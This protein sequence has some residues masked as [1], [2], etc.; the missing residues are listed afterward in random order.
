MESFGAKAVRSC[1]ILT[2]PAPKL[3]KERV[4]MAFAVALAVDAIQIPITG[5]TD[6]IAA[7]IPGEVADF[8]VDCIAMAAISSLIGFHRALIPT[9][10]VELI[11]N[12][13]LFPTWTACVAYIVHQRKL[14]EAQEQTIS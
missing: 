1:Y 7:A 5:L 12:V 3:T 8:A 9:M 11:P 4:F 2:M 6:T 14:E 13:D 10:F